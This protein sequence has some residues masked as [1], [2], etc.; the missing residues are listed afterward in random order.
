MTP[1]SIAF[2]PTAN[3][4]RAGHAFA[5]RLQGDAGAA[6][7][8][9][10]VDPAARAMAG[11]ASAAVGDG[12]MV[13]NA[14]HAYSFGVII[15]DG[16]GRVKFANRAAETLARRGAGIL[17]NRGQLSAIA[18]NQAFA[19]A[20]LIRDAATGGAGGAIQL[21]GCDGARAILGLVT[22]LP[23]QT[24]Q[25]HGGHALVSLRAAADRPT[26]TEAA[27]AAMFRLSPSQASIARAIFDGKAPEEIAHE[28][29]VRISTLRSHLTEIFARTGTEN[30]R[31][32]VRLLAMLPPLLC[33]SGDIP[34]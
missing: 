32:L 33:G 1:R 9:I 8:A 11:A 25:T 10:D 3:A 31:D 15:S 17:L 2:A 19:L 26:L 6:N 22:P 28:R 21:T 18:R 34:C 14:L 5:L 30:Q 23:R 16:G 20:R 24:D 12:S 4:S 29:G 27:L 13:L 7:H